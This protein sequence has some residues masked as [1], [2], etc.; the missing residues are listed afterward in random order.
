MNNPMNYIDPLGLKERKWWQFWKPKEEEPK[1]FLPVDDIGEVTVVAKDM[2]QETDESTGLPIWLYWQPGGL[3]MHIPGA[4]GSPGVW[5]THTE[6]IGNIEGLLYMT[7]YAGNAMGSYSPPTSHQH[8]PL[9]K[10]E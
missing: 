7:G 2:S 9:L 3:T 6:D 8:L 4:T 5:A 10:L 1:P